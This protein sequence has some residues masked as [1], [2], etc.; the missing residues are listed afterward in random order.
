MYVH[1]QRC[2]LA[3]NSMH[4]EFWS[5]VT[6]EPIELGVLYRDNEALRAIKDT[7][8]PIPESEP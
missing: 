2:Q 5:D 4:E 8:N 1:E 6:I 7:I 3:P